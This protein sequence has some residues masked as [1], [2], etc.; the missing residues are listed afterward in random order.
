MTTTPVAYK[1]FDTAPAPHLIPK[2]LASLA[3]EIN[4]L[5]SKANAASVEVGRLNH[6]RLTGEAVAA[7]REQVGAEIRAGKTPKS[8]TPNADKLEADRKAAEAKRDALAAA[9][10]AVNTEVCAWLSQHGAELLAH[11][12]EQEAKA[13]E[14]FRNAVEMLAQARRAYAVAAE[15][16]RWGEAA[17]GDSSVVSWIDPL[18]RLDD[19]PL[20]AVMAEAEKSKGI[21]QT[22]TAPG[23]GY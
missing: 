20:R 22:S 2:G 18:G 16:K 21:R 1:R 19:S 10:Q 6:N 7:D 11:V 9:R 3:Q 17:A 8:L 4:D 23:F 15:A 5:R 13:A 12:T 14:D